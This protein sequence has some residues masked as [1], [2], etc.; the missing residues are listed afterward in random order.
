MTPKYRTA[1]IGRTGRGNYGHGL[2]VVWKDVENAEIVAV[3]DE[4]A[5]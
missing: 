1:V 3:A 4:D 2:D 5:K